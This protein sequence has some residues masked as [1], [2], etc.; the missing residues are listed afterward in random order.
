MEYHLTCP[1]CGHVSSPRNPHCSF[2]ERGWYCFVCGAHGSLA[3]LA[4]LVG[5]STNAQYTPPSSHLQPRRD[6]FPWQEHPEAIVERYEAHGARYESWAKYKPV[7]REMIISHHLGVGVLPSSR[8]KHDRLIVPI[9]DGTLIVG[10]RG[11]SMGCDCGKWL[12]AGGTLLEH[13]PLY[14]HEAIRPGCTVWIV[15]NPVDALLVN[16]QTPYFGVAVYSTSYWREAWLETLLA[17]R[18]ELVVV[19]LDNDLVGLG[20]DERRS[21]FIETWLLT[22]PR[23]PEP[24]GIKIL[25][26]LLAAGLHA[27]PYRWGKAEYKADIGGL[28]SRV[29]A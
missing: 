16:E 12:A 6:S 13:M 19:A 5:L 28:L 17:A 8:C 20:G 2:N 24:A 10:L 21:E 22:H 4:K 15:E 27:V 1:E 26:R 11:R 9:Y 14:N 3:N 23:V 7:S 18:P 25:N 29:A